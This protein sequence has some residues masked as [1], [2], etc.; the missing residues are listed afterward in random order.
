MAN[1][2]LFYLSITINMD[3]APSYAFL[4]QQLRAL[5]CNQMETVF[6]EMS[7]WT[8]L[9]WD[10]DNIVEKIFER[11]YVRIFIMVIFFITYCR[12]MH[13]HIRVPYE[14]CISF[15]IFFKY[16]WMLRSFK[17]FLAS[18]MFGIKYCLHS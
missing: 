5:W 14:C 15:C 4:L 10:A 13:I 8:A 17:F 6:A 1:L 9:K 18:N 7:C 16:S 12:K 3:P 11:K 2:Y